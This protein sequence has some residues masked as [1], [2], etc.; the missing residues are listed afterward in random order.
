MAATLPL[1]SIVLE[2][3]APDIPPDFLARGL[4]NK[5]EYL[6]RIAQTLAALRDISLEDIAQATSANAYSAVP[7]LQTSPV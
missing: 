3:D 2:T 6:P 7:A 5:P 1:E 4:P